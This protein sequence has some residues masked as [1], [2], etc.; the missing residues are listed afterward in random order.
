MGGGGGGAGSRGLAVGGGWAGARG[1][2]AER[3]AIGEGWRRWREA[4]REAQLPVGVPSRLVVTQDDPAAALLH[5][6]G[7][8]D[9]LV[10][11]TH[12]QGRLAGLVAGSVSKAVLDKMTC[13]V[14]VVQPGLD[15]SRA[16]PSALAGHFARS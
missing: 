15:L 12:G 3:V 13:D 10:V 1:K 16:I 6:V 8:T 7:A 4:L 5:R 9:L 11:G 2:D 14:L